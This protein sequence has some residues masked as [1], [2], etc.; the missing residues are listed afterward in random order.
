M[1]GLMTILTLALLTATTAR[2]E[3]SDSLQICVQ[4]GD[5]STTPSRR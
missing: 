1:K 3:A 4:Q 5:S 2:G